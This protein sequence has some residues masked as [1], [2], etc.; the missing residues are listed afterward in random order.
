[1]SDLTKSELAVEQ[2][3]QP[4]EVSHLKSAQTLDTVHNDEALKV[5][6]NYSGD[7]TWTDAEENRLRRKVDW[8]LMPIL[9]M[10]YGLV[11]YD[12]AM[13]SQA[14]S[15]C[16]APFLFGPQNINQMSEKAL[17][18]LMTDLELSVGNRY[19]FSAS[20]FYLGFIAGAYPAVVLAQRFP[21]ERVASAI[22]TVWGVCLILSTI[23]KNYQGFYTQRFFLGFLESGISPMFMLIVGTWYKKNEQAMRMG[24]VKLQHVYCVRMD[25]VHS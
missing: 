18:G 7:S 9:C 11:Y 16:Q 8:R 1:M 23:C 21:V 2:I 15:Y 12:K 22:V 19:S 25:Y 3:D 17:F 14:V 24:Y 6:D 4:D 5:L 10:T 13:L 20:I